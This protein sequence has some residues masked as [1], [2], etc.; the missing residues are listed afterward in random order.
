LNNHWSPLKIIVLVLCLSLA[1]QAQQAP[2]HVGSTPT[3]V[4]RGKIPANLPPAAR[5]KPGQTVVIDTLSHQGMSSAVGPV[6]FF[7]K[8]GIKSGDVLKD[9]VDVYGK[10][11]PATGVSGHV[12]TGPIYVEGAEPGDQLEVRIMDIQFRVPYG[13]NSTNKGTGVLPDLLSEPSSKIIH[14]DL[15]RKVALFAS[16]IEVPLA[17][18]MGV[19]AVAPPPPSD[20]SVVSSRPPGSFGGNLDLKQLTKGATLYLPVY[21]TGAQFFT[22]DAHGIQGDGEVDGTA[23]EMSLSPTVKFVVNKGKGKDMAFPRAETATHYIAIGMD[24]DLNLAMKNAVQEAVNFLMK[25]KGLSSA[26]AY[27]LASIGVDFRVAESVNLV[28]VVYGMIP[29]S[30]FKTNQPYWYKP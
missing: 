20:G 3:T 21:N 16:G 11:E 25:E 2:V 19:M 18:F 8:G 17:P 14:L 22:G 29:K 15:Q 12:L 24:K 6:E 13:V 23:I 10:I 5:V 1:A 26:D 28:Q 30:L 7:A 9:A 4:V 27:S